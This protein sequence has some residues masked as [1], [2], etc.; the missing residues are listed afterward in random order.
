MNVN[1][2]FLNI[3][4]MPPNEIKKLGA[5]KYLTGPFNQDRQKLIFLR[6]KR[7]PNAATKDFYPT[8]E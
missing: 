5:A 7:H 4:T 1:G 8:W 3:N 2:A 6:P